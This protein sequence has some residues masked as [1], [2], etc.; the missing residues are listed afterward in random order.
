M[1]KIYMYIV[2]YAPFS[3]SQILAELI[4]VL[5]NVVSPE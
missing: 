2:R 1:L 5:K 4:F 3:K